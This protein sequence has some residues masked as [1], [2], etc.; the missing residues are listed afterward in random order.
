MR[1]YIFYFALLLVGC[2]NNGDDGSA[3]TGTGPLSIAHVPEITELVLFPD[4]IPYMEGNGSVVVTAEVSFRDAGS[5]LHA[6]GVRMPDGTTIEFDEPISTDTGAISED[7]T[8]STQ[9]VGVI[10]F[11]FWLVD[12]AGDSSDPVTAEFRV[13]A[14]L[15]ADDWTNRLSGLPY[16][17]GDVIW[18]GDAFIAVGSG[19]TV[20]TSADGITWV[21]V[22]SGTGADLSAVAF[23]GTDIYAVGD[24]IILQSADHGAS[25]TVKG[26]ITEAVL[27]AVAVNSSQVVVGG[28]RRSWG[29][30]ITLISEDRGD[31]WQ[32]VDSW[33]NENA[34][35]ND[36]VS[37]DGLFVASTPGYEGFEAWVTVS[38]DGKLWNEIAVGDEG[39]WAVPHT[40][41]HDGS[42][43]I[44][45]G[46]DGTVFTSPDGFNWTR[47]QTP[48]RQVFYTGAAWNGSKL[49][50]AGASMCGGM[51]LCYEPFDVPLG[52]SSTDGGMT[53][54]L[55]NIDSN[56]ESSGLAWGNGRFVSVGDR[57]EFDEEGA[58]Y[59]AE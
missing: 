43:F 27:Q 5:D 32:A 34:H 39:E 45:A 19:G 28:Y 42:Q 37:R 44:L 1:K 41:I 52:L 23:Y 20:L 9:T 31:T 3:D 38:S 50:L 30:A 17:L 36:L 14:K 8:I 6:L 22:E 48:V 12:Q 7:L 55:F 10:M 15:Q 59:T 26:R 56:Y 33:P 54:E 35:M 47:L 29:T 49:V 40:I 11:E 24:E 18:D 16:A 4:T 53:W 57:P 46:L 58:I 25:W 13:L 2:V 51:W 21:A